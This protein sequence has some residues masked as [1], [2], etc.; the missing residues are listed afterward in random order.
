M[1]ALVEEFSRFAELFSEPILLV[2]SAGHLCAS[3]RSARNVLFGNATISPEQLMTQFLTDNP[4]KVLEYLRACSRSGQ[5]LPGV[6][7]PLH[8]VHG[9]AQFR[10][11]GSAFGS[12]D[13]QQRPLIVLRLTRKD[14]STSRFVA[15]NQQ[16]EQLRT[17]ISR[18][19]SA[20]RVAQEQ[21]ELLQVT[22]ASIGD[23]VIATDIEGRITFMNSAAEAH[24]GY[25]QAESVD[26]AL[27]E[28][29]VIR[30]EQTG[31]PAENPLHK[32][33][34][35]G[36]V[37]GLANH[38]VLVRR[39]GQE[40]PIDDSA[41]PIRDASG[42]LFGVI[43]VFHEV[44]ESRKLQQ[45]LMRQAEA[46]KEADRRKDEF[47][48]V[49]AHELR[50]PLAPLRN[51]LQIARLRI[52][53]D[54]TLCRA[55]DMMDRQLSHLVRLVDDLMDLNRVSRGVIELR[56]AAVSMADV[57]ARAVEAVRA[58]MDRRQHRLL[59]QLPARDYQIDGDADRLAQIFA[60]LLLNS[61]KYSPNGSRIYLS[62][63]HEGCEV[64]VTVKDEG[65]GIPGEYLEK[66]FEMFSQVR[67][68][69]G[70]SEGGLGIGLSLVR[71]LVQMHGG[72]IS[73]SSDGAGMGSAFSVRLPMLREQV[74]DAPL[75]VAQ[76]RRESRSLRVLVADDN[77][78]AANSLRLLLEL[79]GH[80][81]R[82]AT[83]GREAL[84]QA[85]TFAPMLIFMDV[86][87]PD[88]DGIEATRLIRDLPHGQDIV[89]VALT[90]WGQ[91]Q[92][93]LRTM[94]AGVNR[95]IVKPISPEDIA[96]VL[97]LANR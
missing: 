37:V 81:V 92:D 22:L 96:A 73:V 56:K 7:T 20:E 16:I 80:V 88:L 40:L 78:D 34:R 4:E 84:E 53:T 45:E 51:G 94:V 72:S 61:A 15:L 5:P 49:L 48:A 86:G 47:L 9:P 42:R 54:E 17:E 11:L 41:A 43:L 91:P 93:R 26:R 31:A 30:H 82:V 67:I 36:A 89:I 77:L 14:A 66:V 23:A 1:S 65:I 95:H 97:A 33:L 18:R 21:R 10:S 70:R 52:S 27:D 57:L 25:S 6:F 8:S 24:T 32:V 44:S 90:G 87:M 71:T 63:D 62:L 75:V 79:E 60:N 3:N 59:T 19:V 38:T 58:D 46:L 2:S 13:A 39:D 12:R 35:T 29:F 28:V 74:Q 76:A 64:I 50:N 55:I 68:H 69:Q 85:R 83:T